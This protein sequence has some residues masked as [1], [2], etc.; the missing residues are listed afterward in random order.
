MAKVIGIGGV[1]FKSTDP[2]ALRKWYKENLGMDL[3]NEYGASYNWNSI[4]KET[5]K[6]YTVWSP[7]K[8][9][10]KYFSPSTKSFMI[11]LIVDDL[12]VLLKQLAANG[13]N[14]LG[15]TE[16]LEYGSF[17][18]ILDPEGNKIELWEPID[19]SFTQLYEGKTTK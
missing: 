11:N 16:V 10:T 2:E 1:F 7:F 18:W 13:I 17:A 5:N 3:I 19:S 4:T 8:D 14:Q 9:D 6:A 15:E 12:P